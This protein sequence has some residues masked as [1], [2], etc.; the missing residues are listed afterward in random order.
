ME[1]PTSTTGP[2]LTFS[3]KSARN[4]TYSVI[5]IHLGRGGD[6]PYPGKSIA[7]TQ[8][9]WLSSPIKGDMVYHELTSRGSSMLPGG[10]AC[11]RLRHAKSG[12]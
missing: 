7:I 3:M 10:L 12:H 6:L 8:K 11:P 2:S 5:I 4:S 9:R 1:W